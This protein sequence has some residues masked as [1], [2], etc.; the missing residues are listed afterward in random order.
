MLAHCQLPK[1]RR[2]F[3]DAQLSADDNVAGALPTFQGA[4]T[5]Y[6]DIPIY[7]YVF[8]AGRKKHLVASVIFMKS[9]NRLGGR[10]EADC[11]FTAGVRKCFLRPVLLTFVHVSRLSALTTGRKKH[12][13]L[14]VMLF[15]IHRPARQ[16]ARGE[17]FC[18]R[19]VSKS[20]F[21]GRP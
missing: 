4:R 7:E 5:L 17:V 13:G 1:A 11:F 2:Q 20:V 12:S 21:H 15:E 9:D 8:T 18:L 19:P 3:F 10:P 6:M 14:C 16:L